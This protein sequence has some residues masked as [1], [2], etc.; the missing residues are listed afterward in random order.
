V[1]MGQPLGS[2][3]IPAHNE[4]AVIARCL[5]ALLADFRPGELDVVVS[6]NGCTDGTADI[7][8]SGRH[9][10]R[11]VEIE[12]ASKSAALRA[13]DETAGLFPRLYL[14]ADVVLTSGAARRVLDCLAS[15]AALAARP[16]IS[17]NTDG[18]SL[19]VRSY[20]RARTRVPAVMNSLWG[21]GVYGL[22]AE[23]R[24][25]FR[26]FPDLIGDDLFVDQ[27]FDREEIAI[28][29]ASP[30]VVNT[31][32]R[33]ADMLRILRRAY[34]GNAQNRALAGSP[35]QQPGTTG[36]T[37]RDLV[38]LALREP[39]RMADVSVYVAL[40]LLAR[41]T[42]T[43]GSSHTWERD[44]SSRGTTQSTGDLGRLG[45]KAPS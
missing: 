11:V 25:R 24:S 26:E 6:C 39:A 9:Q 31:P 8:R 27:H 5:D 35:A 41:A 19:V 2:V 40:A 43:A 1:T 23:G 36:G 32:R 13:A 4:A 3:V 37:T 21:A 45:G 15:A 22:S 7:V 28:V 14:D 12:T 33:T 30:V 17:Y 10:V 44:D 29:D 18:S 16:P 20:Y 42:L 34:Q 38:R